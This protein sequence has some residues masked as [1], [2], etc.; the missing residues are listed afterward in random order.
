MLHGKILSAVKD[1]LP[2]AKAAIQSKI[3]AFNLELKNK[4]DTTFLVNIFDA[5]FPL[6]ITT[7]RAPI[8][9]GANN[10]LTIN[11]DGTFFDIPEGTTHVENNKVFPERVQGALGNSQQLFIHESMLASL[12]FA[13]DSQ[14]FPIKVEDQ[15][16]TSM[17][18]GTFFEMKKYYGADVHTELEINVLANDGKFISLN[19]SAGIEIGKNGPA[20]L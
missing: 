10:L 12:F 7:T 8:L 11:L 5:N 6:N 3:E 16:V 17:F 4:D 18:V 15:N 1:A 13:L 9:D 14:F 20:T 2:D 19:K